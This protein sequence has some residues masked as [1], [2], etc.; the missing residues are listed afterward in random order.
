MSKSGEM[1][2]AK[3]SREPKRA[4]GRPVDAATLIVVDRENDEPRILMGKRRMDLAFMPGKYVFPGGRVDKVDRTIVPCNELKTEETTKL[5]C[6]MKGTRSEARARAIALA[7]IRETFEEAGLLIGER[8]TKQE[9]SGTET[10][11]TGSAS[12]SETD[13]SSWQKFLAHGYQP[14][15]SDM[16]FLARAITPPGRSRRFDTRFFCIDASAVCLR[17][18]ERDDELSSLHWLT[19]EE[20]KDFDLPGITK[21]VLEDLLERLTSDGLSRNDIAVPYYYFLN[22]SFR[23]E[24]IT[25]QAS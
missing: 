12:A 17:T 21:V 15:L 10:S 11:E 18:E 6:D 16:I 4:S 7:A 8:T 5:L 1:T 3:K 24:L 20:T 9:M 2:D 13:M 25:A 14:G 23:R 22:G 19:I